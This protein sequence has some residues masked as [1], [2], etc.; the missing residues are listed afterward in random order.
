[1][2]YTIIQVCSLAACSF[3]ASNEDCSYCKTVWL[4]WKTQ[5]L[6]HHKQMKSLKC[7]A[8]LQR[9]GYMA[10]F[11][12]SSQFLLSHCAIENRALHV[13]K[14]TCTGWMLSVKQSKHCCE[15][16]RIPVQSA[17]IQYCTA[18]IDLPNNGQ[19]DNLLYHVHSCSSEVITLRGNPA[20]HP[21]KM[22][23]PLQYHA[24]SGE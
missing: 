10:S 17:I 9:K 7:A 6:L 14:L 4:F 24:Q 18:D 21:P 1:M 8:A 3:C 5:H 2:L 13:W 23:K 22:P 15:C 16:H 11:Y 19:W 12:Q 20:P